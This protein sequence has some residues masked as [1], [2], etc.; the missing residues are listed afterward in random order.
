[1]RSFPREDE[2]DFDYTYKAG[3]KKEVVLMGARAFS[4]LLISTQGRIG[5][6]NTTVTLLE[7]EIQA[8]TMLLE[9]NPGRTGTEQEL[10]KYRGELDNS[11]A[12]IGE[13]TEFYRKVKRDWSKPKDRIIGYVFWAPPISFSTSPN[14]YT[15]DVCVIKL[16][17]EK[18]LE[19]FRGNVVDLGTCRSVSLKASKLT[20]HIPGPDIDRVKF[21]QMMY[22]RVDMPHNFVYPAGRLLKLNGILSAEK[23]CEANGKDTSDPSTF[24]IKHGSATQITIGRLSG[25]KSQV[26]RYFTSGSQDSMEVA[27]LPYDT[28]RSPFSRVG[29]SGSIIVDASGKF[30][31]LLTAGA[32]LTDFSDITYGSPMCW[33]WELIKSKFPGADLYFGNNA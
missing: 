29:D 4:D 12:A 16:Y 9:N 1:V 3:H 17:E 15:V 5:T 23:I 6:M 20:L 7:K 22:P 26:R 27:V 25:I 31:A 11:R 33:L 18:F 14:G 19:N 32:G 10:T 13:L 24:V 30:V 2:C 8:L 28:Q 21:T